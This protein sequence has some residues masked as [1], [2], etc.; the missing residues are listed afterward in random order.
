[1]RFAFGRWVVA[2]AVGAVLA[3]LCPP[4]GR[5]DS[6]LAFRAPQVQAGGGAA[7][8]EP[9]NYVPG[10]VQLFEAHWQGL[11]GRLMTEELRR[12][13]Q[14]PQGV[15][16]I[17]VGEVT[18]NAAAAGILAGDIIIKVDE[19]TVATIE[20]F[21]RQTRLVKDRQQARLTFLRKGKQAEAGGG[22]TLSQLTVVLRGSPDLGFA[23]VEGAPMI[24]PGAERP[25]PYRGPC[26]NCHPVGRGFELTPDP[27]LIT[28]P[29]PPITAE[30]AS[31]GMRP[32]ED[33]GPCEACHV[34][35]NPTPGR[36]PY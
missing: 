15:Q 10:K 29:P 2:V 6:Q 23:Q 19:G 31:G 36:P 8:A 5:A 7:Q 33:K 25:H 28:L 17:L 24:V 26:T 11:D 3:G 32:H 27:D 30:K 16:G 34:I 1:M 35:V 22:V 4:V 9:P 12:K 20:D 13:L 14:F 21:Q 18:L